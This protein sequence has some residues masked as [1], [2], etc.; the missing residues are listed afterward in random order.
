MDRRAVD[1]YS[2]LCPSCR[3]PNESSAENCAACGESLSGLPPGRVLGQRYEIV[4]P[5]GKG[6]MGMVF[7]ARDRVLDETV[8]LKVLRTDVV[9]TPELARRFRQEIKLARRVRHKNVCG[10]HEYGE[11][12]SLHFIVMDLVE[13]TDLRREV[14]RRGPLPTREACD[15]ALRIAEGLAAIHEE[16][17]VHRDMKTANIMIDRNG[18]VRLMDFGIAKATQDAGTGLTATGVI[19]G[20]PEYMSPEQ[21]RGAAIDP[22]SDIY[23][24]GIILYEILTG[25]VPFRGDTPI[26]TILKQ[27]Q[28]QPPLHGAAAAR[29]PHELRPILARALEKDPE[30]RFAT[31]REMTTALRQAMT[32][33]EMTNGATIGS[34]PPSP[35]VATLAP[36]SKHVAP[37][38]PPAPPAPA[39]PAPA[40]PAPAPADPRRTRQARLPAAAIAWILSGATIG[41][42]VVAILGAFVGP[43]LLRLLEV[44]PASATSAPSTPSGPSPA[45][46]PLAGKEQPPNAQPVAVGSPQA[47]VPAAAA[48]G[49]ESDSA[50]PSPRSA[51]EPGGSL[52]VVAVPWADVMVDGRTVE[53][54]PMRRIS[55][56]AGP[57]VV[58]LLHPD[59]QPLQRKITIKPGETLT[60]SIDL[61]EDAVPVRR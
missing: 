7:E 44:A 50:A 57:H 36:S 59:Y 20:T 38:R 30:A 34:R 23:A 28:E 1:G 56:A 24:L 26:S 17:I 53:V 39:P 12:G 10:I 37:A 51:G 41:L 16:G 15:V 61:A 49:P 31:A 35:A 43:R 32:A 52:R 21:A 54:G 19:V 18:S 58:R 48:P 46:A 45:S 42:L 8:A 2:M 29:I 33:L 25:D 55:L 5:L 13:G 6:G 47:A 14:Q 27:I 60:L 40:P 22:R 4:R 11:D 9:S 3:V